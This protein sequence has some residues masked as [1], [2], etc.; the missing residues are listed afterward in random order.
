MYNVNNCNDT[1]FLSSSLAKCSFFS[2]FS[3][4]ANVHTHSHAILLTLIL[5]SLFGIT[6]TISFFP[7][8]RFVSIRCCCACVCVCVCLNVL[9]E[10]TAQWEIIVLNN[11]W[12]VSSKEKRIVQFIVVVVV[13]RFCKW[14]MNHSFYIFYNN[15]YLRFDWCTFSYANGF[16]SGSFY[17][18]R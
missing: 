12:C 17:G 5:S 8:Q 4:F 9:F 1:R 18:H 7:Q 11:D 6:L 2:F 16:V 14:I 13:G 3:F 15:I 10:H